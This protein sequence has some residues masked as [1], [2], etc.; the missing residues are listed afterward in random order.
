[1]FKQNRHYAGINIQDIMFDS[2]TASRRYGC[3]S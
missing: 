1:M 3:N 2:I